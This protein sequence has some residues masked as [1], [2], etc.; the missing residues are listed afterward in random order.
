MFNVCAQVESIFRWSPKDQTQLIVTLNQTT[1]EKVYT[2]VLGISDKCSNMCKRS[3]HASPLL[4]V[5]P[6]TVI[7]QEQLRKV[8]RTEKI[9]TDT[10]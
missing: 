1:S 2:Q 7:T 4:R 3:D 6:L 5:L 9:H 10:F 8:C